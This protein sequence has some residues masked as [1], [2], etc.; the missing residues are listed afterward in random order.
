MSNAVRH[1]CLMRN[2]LKKLY[3]RQRLMSII[4]LTYRWHCRLDSF[5]SVTCLQVITLRW[6]IIL[7]MS[8]QIYHAEHLL[9]LGHRL[10][11]GPTWHPLEQRLYWVNIEDGEVHRCLADGTGHECFQLP[12][13]VGAFAF[14]EHGGLMLAVRD[15]FAA[16]TPGEADV[17]ML[18]VIAGGFGGRR[19]N[20][21]KADPLG[22][23]IAGT[24]GEQGQCALYRLT[25]TG[26]VVRLDAG[27][28]ICNGLDWSP[29]RCWYYFTDTPSRTI[30]RYRYDAVTG[31]IF[32]R[33]DFITVPDAPGEGVPD[34]LTVDAEGCIWSARWDGWKVVR[35]APDGKQ[36]G[37]VRV[38]AAKVTSCAFGG[39]WLDTLYITTA[40][41]D[42]SASELESQPQSG[43]L[44]MLKPGCRG[45]PASFFEG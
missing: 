7:C 17:R 35:Y 27:F 15:G 37:E 25:T 3:G 40:R 21:G 1:C 34:G 31:E 10:G 39:P 6:T 45:L 44:F 14:R 38:P 23:F 12:Q 26:D 41:A 8:Y 13:P 19:F 32:D 9:S 5:A 22:G 4:A 29:D 36:I 20:D 2:V 16:W 28:T 30:Y 18:P 33:Q 24:I 43:D 11:E 42:S